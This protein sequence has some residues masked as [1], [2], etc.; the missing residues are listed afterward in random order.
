MHM[1]T[2]TVRLGVTLA[3]ATLAAVGCSQYREDTGNRSPDTGE[4]R[5]FEQATLEAESRRV[6]DLYRRIDGT[7][8]RFFRDSVGYAVF[9]SVTRGGAGISG[10]SG[11]GLVFEGGDIITG[12]AQLEQFAVGATVGGQEFSQIVFFQ[13]AD[14]LNRFKQDQLELNANLSAIMVESGAGATNDFRDGVAALVQPKEGLMVDFSLGVQNFNFM[15][16]NSN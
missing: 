16:H 10:A 13:N 12:T 14:A 9:P 15:P 3:A 11:P 7:L 8:A 4:I 1:T 5:E 6:I 2:N